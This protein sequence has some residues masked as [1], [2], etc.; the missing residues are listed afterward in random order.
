VVECI[1]WLMHRLTGEWTGSITGVAIRAYYDRTRGGWPTDLYEALSLGD[2]MA[3][4]AH[5]VRDLGTP[6]G[7]LRPEVA[8]ELGLSASTLVAQGGVDAFVAQIGLNVLEPGRTA[9]ITGSSHLHLGQ[10]AEEVDAPGGPLG[11][12]GAGSAQVVER[13]LRRDDTL[14]LYTDGLLE[15]AAP[16]HVLSP[17]DMRSLLGQCAGMPT[18]DVVQAIEREA[19]RLSGGRPR[20]DLAILAVTVR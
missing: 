2:L 19:L 12:P 17:E 3:K 13:T 18:R 7:A 16:H 10:V 8:A 1:D 15:A 20:D 6:V 9:L 5:D 4:V 14:I 11:W